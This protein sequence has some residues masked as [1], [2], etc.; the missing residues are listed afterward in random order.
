MELK[1]SLDE[2]Q[3]VIRPLVCRLEGWVLRNVH[4][5]V[6]QGPNRRSIVHVACRYLIVPVAGRI[7]R[8][9]ETLVDN[10]VAD[11]GKEPQVVPQRICHLRMLKHL[12]QESLVVEVIDTEFHRS[13]QDEEGL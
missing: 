8:I 11:T 6:A 2:P 4:E 13:A 1:R 9:R 10:Q 7:M 3:P 5:P 12:V